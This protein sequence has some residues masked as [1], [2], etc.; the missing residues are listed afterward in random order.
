MFAQSNLSRHYAL[1]A[2]VK[3]LAYRLTTSLE[4]SSLG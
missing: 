2:K 4:S 1:A 3:R